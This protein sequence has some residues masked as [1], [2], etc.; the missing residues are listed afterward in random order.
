MAT[1]ILQ[2]LGFAIIFQEIITGPSPRSH[3]SGLQITNPEH[4]SL[5][6]PS[7]AQEI[8]LIFA[9]TLQLN[10]ISARHFLRI[11]GLMASTIPMLPLARLHMR[12]LQWF[13]KSV[14]SQHAH[15]LEHLVPLLPCLKQELQ[16]WISELSVNPGLSLF[17]HATYSD[18]IYRCL[19]H[20]LG[21]G[22]RP[23]HS[24]RAVVF[25]PNE[26]THK[27]ERNYGTDFSPPNLQVT[28]QTREIVCTHR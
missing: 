3:I 28:D 20:G 19:G 23:P 14:W 25:L 17:T 12:K 1:A 26:Q 27:C 4:N 10:Q 16:W 7:K 8:S 21:G 9:E 18:L 15:H 11:L 13:L 6:S 5:S 24:S 22:I 2:N